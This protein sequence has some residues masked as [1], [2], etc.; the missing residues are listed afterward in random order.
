MDDFTSYALNAMA[1]KNGLH[2]L[3]ADLS[4]EHKLF[5][6][7]LSRVVKMGN[8]HSP[9]ARYCNGDKKTPADGDLSDLKSKMLDQTHC[10]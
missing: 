9:G 6:T 4:T 10:P 3:G 8:S 2:G 7:G 1:W 5:D